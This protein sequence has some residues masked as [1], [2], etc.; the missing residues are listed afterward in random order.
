MRAMK[1]KR[2]YMDDHLSEREQYYLEQYMIPKPED[3]LRLI[4]QHLQ[5]AMS[6]LQLTDWPIELKAVC[7]EIYGGLWALDQG[8]EIVLE[9][10]ISEPTKQ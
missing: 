8:I 6:I 2:G 9:L 5:A 3:E 1:T 7:A 10:P 4:G